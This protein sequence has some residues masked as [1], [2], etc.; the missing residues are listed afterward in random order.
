VAH[1]LQELGLPA[2]E[3][4]VNEVLERIKRLPKGSIVD[5][6]LLRRLADG[7]SER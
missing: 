7:Q 5:E 4:E 1:R 3:T 2:S 6:A